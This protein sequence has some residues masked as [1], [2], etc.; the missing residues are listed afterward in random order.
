MKKIFSFPFLLFVA[1]AVLVSG[2]T[3]RAQV[4]GNG[5]VKEQTR[6]LNKFQSIASVGSV[7]VIVKQ[8]DHFSAVVRADENLIPYIKTEVKNNTLYVS[9]SRSIWDAK[10]L[11][12]Y[13]TTKDLQR[14]MLSGSGDFFCKTPF[15]T[16]NLQLIISGSGDVEAALQAENVQVK[17]SGSGDVNITGIRGNLEVDGVGSGD[18]Q[19]GGLQLESCSVKLAGSGDVKL[20]GRTAKLTVSV[21]GSGDVDARELAAVKVNIKDTGSGDV[22]VHA[23]D[24]LDA[25]LMGSGDLRYS[26]TPSHVKVSAH[27]SGDVYKK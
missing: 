13:V 11:E 21:V 19:A 5:I 4:R 2:G 18:V 27:G 16:S 15:K 3:L 22:S 17:V 14:V 23:I 7:D 9:V 12:V 20:K 10:T 24:S 26:G 25:L 8:G 6:I 1:L